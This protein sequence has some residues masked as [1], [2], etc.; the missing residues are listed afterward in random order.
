MK[1]NM[2][3]IAVLSLAL[4]VLLGSCK[5]D[6]DPKF[7]SAEGDWTYTT[8]DGHLVVD[9]TIKTDGSNWFISKQS[10][11]LDGV[12]GN[13][14]VDIT[15]F[16]PPTFGYIRINANDSKLVYAYYVSFLESTVNHDFTSMEASTAAWTYPYNNVNSAT[17]VV[18]KRK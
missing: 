10:I 3:L 13:A 1:T 12:T 2:K 8:P 5:K 14:E 18:I 15:S 6:D 16:T 4:V 9:F 17:K 7:T 11:S